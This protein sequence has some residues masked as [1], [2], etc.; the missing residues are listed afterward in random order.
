MDSTIHDFV[1]THELFSYH[2]HH[3]TFA[4]FEKKRAS[5]NHRTF[6]GY[7]GSDLVTAAGPRPS[8]YTDDDARLNALWPN[9]RTTG[10]GRAVVSGCKELF[11]I[12]YAPKNFERITEALQTT[13]ADMSASEVYDYFVKGKA[14]IRWVAQDGLFRPENAEALQTNLYPDYYR[15]AVR[16]DDL[17]AIADAG[18]LDVLERFT[19]VSILSLD[20]LVTALNTAIDVF[21]ATGRMSAVKIGIAYKRDLI[22]TDPTRHEAEQAFNRIRNRKAFYNGS[23]QNT[24]AVNQHEARALSDYMLH[25]LLE[26]ADDENIPVQVHTGYLAGN[27]CSLA[28]S[29]ALFLIPLFEKYRRVRFDIFHGS[30]PWTSELG[31]IAKNYPN[32]Y[33]DLCW[34]WAM[35]PAETERTLCEW[36]DGVPFNKIFA[37]GA[38]TGLPWIDV[39]YAIQA[40]HGIARVLDNK[41][42]EGFFSKSTAEKVATAIMLKNGEQFYGLV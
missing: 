42:R 15:F 41:V 37:F 31:A 20:R 22:V 33:P 40:R 26:R 9:I 7:A 25:R 17:F 1:M 18:P 39:G 19:N 5:F 30:W 2:D 6:L 27:W 23:Q 24:A 28:G 11:G 34:A 16:M 32:V 13:I 29:K 3:I 8:E 10:Y 38:D 35:N 21:K 4:E 36:L 14:N 12:E